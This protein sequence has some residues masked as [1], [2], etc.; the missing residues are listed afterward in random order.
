MQNILKCEV[1]S[2]TTAADQVLYLDGNDASFMRGRRVLI[3]D[4][5]ISTGESLRALETLV[6]MAGGVTVGKMAVLAEGDAAARSDIV[7]LEKLPL[8]DQNGNAL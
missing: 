1:K 3:V 4:D 2:I 8:F 6:E 5:V 7:Y